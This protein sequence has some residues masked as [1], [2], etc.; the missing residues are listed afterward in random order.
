MVEIIEFWE[1]NE[2]LLCLAY[3]KEAYKVQAFS[4]FDALDCGKTF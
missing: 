1:R 4:L 3:K 2:I